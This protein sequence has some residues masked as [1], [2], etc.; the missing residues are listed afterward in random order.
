MNMNTTIKGIILESSTNEEKLKKLEVLEKEIEIAKGI[1]K[2]EYRYCRTCDDYYLKDS[3]LPRVERK[4]GKICVY[5]DPINSGGNEY[6][7]GIIE[8]TYDLCPKGHRCNKHTK[9][10]KKY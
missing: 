8:T 4:N 1:V 10:Y 3:F 5:Q 6:E 7:D 9:E 2:D